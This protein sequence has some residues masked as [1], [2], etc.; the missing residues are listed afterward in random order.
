VLHANLDNL[1]LSNINK[2][3]FKSFPPDSDIENR[4][5]LYFFA[6]AFYNVFVEWMRDGCHESCSEMA[7]ICTDLTENG[8][9]AVF[10][11]K[12]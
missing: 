6:G 12:D 10:K 2:T 5:R 1:I 11:R 7:R 3:F 9:L 4:Y 8:C